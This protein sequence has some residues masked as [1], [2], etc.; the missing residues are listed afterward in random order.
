[1]LYEPED[2]RA[3]FAGAEIE[4]LAEIET[5]LREGELHMGLSAVVRL[6][7]ARAAVKR[8]PSTKSDRAEF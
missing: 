3:D 4:M 6:I 1:M 2:L 5:D 7:G 8:S